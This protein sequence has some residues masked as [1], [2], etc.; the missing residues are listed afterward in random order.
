M[1]VVA[2]AV[3]LLAGGMFM[4]QFGGCS[5]TDILGGVLGA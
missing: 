4:L 1:K 2:R 5:L 3:T